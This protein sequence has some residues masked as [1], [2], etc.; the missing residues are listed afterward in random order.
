MPPSQIALEIFSHNDKLLVKPHSGENEYDNESVTYE[1]IGTIII[2]KQMSQS[3]GWMPDILLYADGY[4]TDWY[5][6]DYAL[7]NF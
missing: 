3:T 7:T 1:D 6:K 2:C 4:E 5:F